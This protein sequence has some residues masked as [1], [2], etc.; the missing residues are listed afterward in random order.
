M[1]TKFTVQFN[2]FGGTLIGLGTKRHEKYLD[3]VDDL[4]NTG[5]FCLTE[6]G[7]GNNAVEM[8]TTAIWDE[9]DQKFTINTPTV[10]SQKFW[11]T[12][13]AYYAN[14]AVVFAQTIVKGKN[15]GINVFVVRM[16][17]EKMNLCPGVNID[18]MGHKMGLN[19]V[20]NARII[21]KNVKVEKTDILNKISDIDEKGNFTSSI[22]GRRQRFI[23]AANRLLSG[24]ICIGSM[25]IAG[26]KLCLLITSKYGKA[27]LSNGK[28]GKSDTAISNYQLFQ[29]QITPLIVR[30][31]VLNVGLLEIRKI[32]SEFC[33]K[34]ES[35][36]QDQFNNIVRLCCFI[37]PIIAWNANDAGNICRERVGGQGFLSINRIEAMIGS[38]H[39]GITAEGDSSVLM[40]KVSKEYVEDFVKKIIPAP[41]LAG[42]PVAIS[43]K[44]DIMNLEVLNDLLKIRETKLL[45]ILADKT[46]NN[47]DNVYKVWMLEESNLI[48]DLSMVYGERY[49]LEAAIKAFGSK[50][51]LYYLYSSVLV[52]VMTLF[53]ACHVKK[54]L[55]WYL[56]NESISKIA[57]NKIG[58]Q[59]NTLIK[60][61]SKYSMEI[62]E[63]F[64][65]PR[66]SI[67]APIYTG[68]EK[69][70]SVDKTDGEHYDVPFRP[71]F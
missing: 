61:I 11:I 12:N 37:K 49:C 20:D 55:S 52:N 15:E 44:E 51:Y 9:K 17:D 63:G 13:G 30:T 38:A 21:F 2:L 19:G 66:H 68:Y 31:L 14:Y 29:N 22:V 35:F 48:Q 50:K 54:N 6:L 26:T 28:S 69:Y 33:V 5:C 39:S 60:D 36:N 24:R 8:E 40:Q 32:Y 65:I 64:G 10:N 41:K 43:K 62:C 1:A 23:Y 47:L 18:D 7:Y 3:G 27:R 67:F 71:K 58:D 16:R 46:M 4:S 45:E 53:A 25:M 42:C 57:A 70:Y 59:I 34:P 56:L